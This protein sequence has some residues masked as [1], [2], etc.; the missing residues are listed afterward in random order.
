[1]RLLDGFGSVI[2]IICN[3]LNPYSTGNEVVGN[4]MRPVPCSA[5]SLNPY[6]TGNEVVAV[7]E[8]YWEGLGVVGS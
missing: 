5:V 2:K 4:R 3:C 8:E 7:A 1:M 6:S